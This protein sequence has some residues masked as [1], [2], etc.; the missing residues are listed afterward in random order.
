MVGSKRF[1][2]SIGKMILFVLVGLA[3]SRAMAQLPDTIL[4][5]VAY[6]DEYTPVDRVE[7]DARMMKAAGITVV[8]I[9]ESTWGTLEPQPGVFDFSHIDRT[10]A[11]MQRSG[12]KVIVGTPTYAIPTWLARQHPEILVVRR[13]G[14]ARYGPRQNMDITNPEFR[15]EAE[16]VIVALVDHVKDNPAVIGYQVDNE[17]K[18]YG[19]TGANVQTAFVKEMQRKF[20]SLDTLNHAF[21]LDYWS[22]RINRW[23]DFPSVDASINASLSN[24]FSEFQ[25]GLVTEYLA[26]QAGLV[27]AHY[28]PGQFITQ[29]FDLSWQGYSYGVQPEVNHWEAAKALDVAGIDIYYPSQEKLTGAG[30]AFG[31]DVARS[32]KNGKN[33]LL[34]ETEAQGFPNWTPYPGQLRLQAFSHIASGANMVEYWHWATTANGIET[35]WRGVLTQDY[36]PNPTYEEAKTIGADLQRLGS[37]LVNMKKHN[38][39]AMYVSNTALDGFDAFRINTDGGIGYNNVLRSLYDALY[40][41]NVE[42]DLISPSSTVPLSDYKLILVPALYSASDAEIAKLNAYAKA[43]GH[44]VYTFKSG[45]S[46]EN[47]K[48]RYAAQPGGISEAAGVK[49]SEFA[50]PEGVTL[51]GDPFGVGE[52]DNKVRW[53][54]EF[55]NPTTAT[56]LARYKHSSWP[57]YAAVTRNTYGKGEV[58]YVGFMPTDATAEKILEDAVKRA[59]VESLPGAHFP[60]IVRSGTLQ[61]GHLVHYFLNYSKDKQQVSYGYQ[62]GSD[63]LSGK[64]ISRGRALDLAPW[65]VAI[66]EESQ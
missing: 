45:F 48:V 36:Q 22:N 52:Q 25:R 30:I 42:V 31:G 15:R 49:Y 11:A 47:T 40:R 3:A 9:A 4:F 20:P 1:L 59:G 53:W 2:A 55:L 16:R 13:E 64:Q 21:G 57:A 17:T 35:Y 38:Q 62:N 46:D 41:M 51:D 60:M 32:M 18:A 23:E 14:Q 27:R 56:V 28:R 34:M 63:L 50:I 7:E 44:L 54:M 39:V 66:V 37:K 6:Y 19:N 65:G 8:R 5:G 61:N 12:I 26:W 24:A 29:N 43:G 58:T 10:L 33:F